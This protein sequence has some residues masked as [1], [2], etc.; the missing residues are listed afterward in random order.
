M[1]TQYSPRK[2]ADWLRGMKQYSA[3]ADIYESAAQ[4]IEQTP[5]AKHEEAVRLTLST[6]RALHDERC[7]SARWMGDTIQQCILEIGHG[8]EHEYTASAPGWELP[9]RFI[10][11]PSVPEG[12]VEF[13]ARDGSLLGKIVGLF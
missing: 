12:T 5:L 11:D 10:E 6:P 7:S 3:Y 4:A 9:F 2:I 13:R 1:T 8:D